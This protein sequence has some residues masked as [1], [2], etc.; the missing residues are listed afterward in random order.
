M[1]LYFWGMGMCYGVCLTMSEDGLHFDTVQ[2]V[3]PAEDLYNGAFPEDLTILFRGD[4][5]WLMYFR[6]QGKEAD[7]VFVAKRTE[8]SP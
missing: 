4:S 3:L 1:S 8:L 5:A 6:L 2:Q 7:G